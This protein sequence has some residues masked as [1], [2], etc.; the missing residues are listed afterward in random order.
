MFA[1]EFTAEAVD[2]LKKLRS[3]DRKRILDTID[4]RLTAAPTQP[5]HN[6][7]ILVGLKPPWQQEEPIWELRLDPFRV[8]YDVD[9]SAQRVVIRAVRR[10]DPHRTTEDIL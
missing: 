4:C 8:F 7:K 3:Y 10:K 5:T 9:E 2:N 6:Q 1:V